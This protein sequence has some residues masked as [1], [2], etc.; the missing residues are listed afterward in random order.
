MTCEPWP[1][2]AHCLPKGWPVDPEQ[3][4]DAQ[5]AAVETASEILKRLSG[6]RYGLCSLKLRPCRKRCEEGGDPFSLG[7]YNVGVA[8]GPWT[9]VLLDGRMRNITCGCSGQCGC[10]ALCE[11]ILDPPAHD[12]IQVKID[13][14]VVPATAYRVDDGRRLVRTDGVCWP[15]CQ[16][17][18]RPDTQPGTFSVAYRTGV[19][20]PAGGRMAVT[21]LAVQ[22]WKACCG[23]K[24]C[25]LSDR[26]TQVVREGMTYTLDNLDIFERGRTGLNRVDLWLASENPYGIRSPMRAFSVDTIRGRRTTFPDPTLPPV[27][28]IPPPEPL[29]YRWIQPSAAQV[30]TIEHSLGFYPGGVRVEDSNGVDTIGE[31]TY[32]DLNTVRIEFNHA[33]SGV[34]Y[35]S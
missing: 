4:D 22:L 33:L 13:G 18:A 9:P 27:P 30:W 8:G 29:S 11:V 14:L 35:L 26:V 12:I 31:V 25:V 19:P 34:A 21:E 7:R 10:S 23:G 15:E 5:R 2:A 1:L 17:L 3:W 20:V 6:G 32:L 24:G 16:E 28:P